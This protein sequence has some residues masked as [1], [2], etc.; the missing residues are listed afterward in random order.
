MYPIGMALVFI[1]YKMKNNKYHTF[2][3]IPK[4]NRKRQSQYPY[5]L[6]YMTAVY[7]PGLI[8]V[9][10][11]NTQIHDCCLSSWLDTGT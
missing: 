4:S 2:G 1:D 11:L 10:T 6:K 8:K 7:L 9:N 3:T 5:P